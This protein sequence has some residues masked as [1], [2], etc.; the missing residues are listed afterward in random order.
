MKNASGESLKKLVAVVGP[1]GVGKTETGLFLAER[2]S[3]EIVNFDSVQVY[4]YLDIGTAKPSAFERSRV[5]H[6]LIDFLEPDEPFNAARFVELADQVIDEIT[7][8][9]HLPI[10]VGGTGLYL[11]ALLHGLFPVEVPEELRARLKERLEQ[12]GLS[13][14]Y[15][16][17]KKVD[18]EAAAKIHPHDGVRILRALE[19]YYAT[20]RPFSAL[21][22][23]HAFA[24][25]RYLVLK[26]GLTLPREELYRRLEARVDRMLSEGLLEEVKELLARG[27]SPTLKPLQSIGYRHMI[28]YLQGKLSFEEA[29]RLMKRD[30]RHYAKR[31]LTWFR[32][33]PEIVWFQPN[34][35]EQIAHK[36]QE[37]LV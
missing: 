23:E 4:K 22:R 26:V 30:T 21:A 6:H 13:L 19:V 29:V 1:T 28:A 10:L 27:Y 14:L 7:A 11:K 34:E 15:E 2:F 32:A 31:Q 17:L 12:E 5:P 8:R 16:E 3:G 24:S 35:K 36:V 25:R 18:P 37:F 20:G 33:D 9:G